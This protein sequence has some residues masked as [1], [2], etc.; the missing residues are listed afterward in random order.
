MKNNILSMLF[1]YLDVT[2]HKN[3]LLTSAIL[4]IFAF[5]LEK[6][7]ISLM[8]HLAEKFRILLIRHGETEPLFIKLLEA[9]DNKE[10]CA[11]DG[12]TKTRGWKDD[13]EEYFSESNNSPKSPVR[14]LVNYEDEDEALEKLPSVKKNEEEEEGFVIATK[15]R[16]MKISIKSEFKRIR[17]KD[18]ATE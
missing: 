1:G 13:Q 7:I 12:G 4:G 8:S 14:P 15:K 17:I 6:H 5:I 18:E 10:S 11:E 16:P 3:N 2:K 9:Y